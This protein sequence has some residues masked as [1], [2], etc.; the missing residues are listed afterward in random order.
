MIDSGESS[1]DAGL[2]ELREETGIELNRLEPAARVRFVLAPDGRLEDAAVF[3]ALLDAK[4]TLID[5]DELIG[6][7]WLDVTADARSDVSPLD[8]AIAGFVQ[9]FCS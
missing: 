5:N 7:A 6:F 3:Y 8:Y 2:R 1:L 4:P 9:S